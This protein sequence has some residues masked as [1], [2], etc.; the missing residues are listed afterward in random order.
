[1]K[2]I[3]DRQN[4]LM[5]QI[6]HFDLKMVENPCEMKIIWNGNFYYTNQVNQIPG[7]SHYYRIV[8]TTCPLR[9]HS[10]QLSE[11]NPLGRPH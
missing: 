1:M 10:G 7:F 9:P 5:I 3:H 4:I 11:K 8:Q 2:K 6:G